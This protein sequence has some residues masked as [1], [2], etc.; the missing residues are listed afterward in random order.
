M[1][2]VGVCGTARHR[3]TGTDM[4]TNPTV[5]ACARISESGVLRGEQSRLAVAQHYAI[6]HHPRCEE[7]NAVGAIVVRRAVQNGAAHAAHD[8]VPPILGGRAPAYHGGVPDQQA[9]SSI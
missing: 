8:A 7:P 9:M 3:A 5:V 4:E 6:P 1:T 2:F